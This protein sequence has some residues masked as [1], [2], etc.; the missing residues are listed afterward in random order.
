MPRV[1]LSAKTCLPR[2]LLRR[3]SLWANFMFAES[4]VMGIKRVVVERKCPSWALSPLVLIS[5][6]VSYLSIGI[7]PYCLG[8]SGVSPMYLLYSAYGAQWKGRKEL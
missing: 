4:R 6:S 2:V 1:R 8:T 3:E 7:V 5:V